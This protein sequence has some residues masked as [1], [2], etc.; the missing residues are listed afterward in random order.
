M[1]GRRQHRTAPSQRPLARGSLGPQ[2]I[3]RR[4]NFCRHGSRVRHQVAKAA[5]IGK[6]QGPSHPGVS[7]QPVS[8]S[9]WSQCGRHRKLCG[10]CSGSAVVRGSVIIINFILA[11][12]AQ[13]GAV[14][15]PA[16]AGAQGCIAAP[17]GIA[18]QGK[19]GIVA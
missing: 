4:H 17:G 18:V 1:P 15:D 10:W 11:E 14:A 9:A 16:E 12:A 13:P 7:T 19:G 8:V 3:R 5:I 6:G 2:G